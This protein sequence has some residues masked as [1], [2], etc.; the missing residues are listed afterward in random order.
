MV[1]CRGGNIVCRGVGPF[2]GSCW[3][4]LGLVLFVVCR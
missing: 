1:L 2:P 3:D 4:G